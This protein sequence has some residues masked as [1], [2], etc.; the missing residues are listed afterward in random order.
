MIAP[1]LH[2]E[3]SSSC[4]TN[5]NRNQQRSL[6]YKCNWRTVRKAIPWEI[7]DTGFCQK[8]KASLLSG[9]ELLRV[10]RKAK[11]F[12]F[13]SAHFL[14][15]LTHSFPGPLQHH[16]IHFFS[17]NC[18]ILLLLHFIEANNLRL[19]SNT[20]PTELVKDSAINQQVEYNRKVTL[21]P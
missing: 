19:L 2:E 21:K 7:A 5:T 15:E 18:L 12:L 10:E 20:L 3:I 17:V 13:P 1:G 14:S 11:T 6:R 9:D 16:S 8:M 4:K